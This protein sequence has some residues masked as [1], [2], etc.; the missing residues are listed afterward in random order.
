VVVTPG[1]A[2]L[3]ALAAELLSLA[4]HPGDVRTAGGAN[5]FLV[6]PYLADLYTT[7]PVP[8][9]RRSPKKEGDE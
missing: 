8:K 4:R 2:G 5:E 6:P 3:A 9:R 1:E 7:P